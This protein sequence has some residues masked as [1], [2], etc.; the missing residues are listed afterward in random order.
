MEMIVLQVR[1]G[2]RNGDPIQLQ[3]WLDSELMNVPADATVDQRNAILARAREFGITQAS[4]LAQKKELAQRSGLH[5]TFSL[6]ARRLDVVDFA[7][8]YSDMVHVKL[9]GESSHEITDC[10][11]L[12]VGND[13]TCTCCRCVP[14]VS[15]V[16][17][18]PL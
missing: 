9:R 4:V 16:P 10:D 14:P 2:Y 5:T 13:P 3:V 7:R 8:T 17:A 18:E 12:R 1:E 6:H 11:P 15:H